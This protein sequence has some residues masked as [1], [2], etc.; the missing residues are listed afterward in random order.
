MKKIL[1]VE[2]DFS[3]RVLLQDL[4]EDVLRE[5]PDIHIAV[6]GR[7]AVRLVT[8]ALL[9]GAPYDLICLDI[10]MPKMDG[11]TA[12]NLIRELEERHGRGALDGAKIIMT[13]CHHDKKHV[14]TSFRKQCDAYL[15][16]PITRS[17]LEEKLRQL[18][19]IHG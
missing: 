19:F 15:V 5:V 10:S 14:F 7:E 3:G 9:A 12:L 4:M 11:I 8:Q 6:D 13:T 1:L 2:D 18:D 17:H 16:K